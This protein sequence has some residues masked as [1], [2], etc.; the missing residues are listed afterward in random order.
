MNSSCPDRLVMRRSASTAGT[1]TTALLGGFTLIELLV[2]LLIMGLLVGLVSA[3]AQPDD[4]AVLRL[5]ADRLAQLMNLAATESRFSGKAIAWT[6]NASA[7]RF[8]RF[9]E[10]LGW[11]A[12]PDEILRPRSLPKGMAIQ[13]MRIENLRSPEP[14]RVEFNPYGAAGAFSI[15]MLL[16]DAR[17]TVENSPIGDVRVLAQGGTGNE[18]P[19]RR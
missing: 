14:M 9:S 8:W 18:S 7:Y 15:D 12:I 17:Y 6:A 13:E 5:E 3:S 4:K 10:T 2:V 19:I 11:V 1:F 16:G